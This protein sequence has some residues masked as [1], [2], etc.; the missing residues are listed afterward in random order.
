MKE[1]TVPKIAKMVKEQQN[2][3]ARLQPKTIKDEPKEPTDI[4]A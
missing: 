2:K 3:G 1:G 4:Y